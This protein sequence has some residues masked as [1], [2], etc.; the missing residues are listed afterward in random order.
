MN[1]N[2]AYSV[3][4]LQVDCPLRYSDVDLLNNDVDFFKQMLWPEW[5]LHKS[6]RSHFI[7][8]A[9]SEIS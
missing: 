1:Q 6:F 2:R 8:D 9:I 3:V 4:R 7:L 5:A